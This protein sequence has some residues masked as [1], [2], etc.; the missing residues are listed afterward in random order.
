MAVHETGTALSRL[1]PVQ[2]ETAPIMAQEGVDVVQ[3][4][5]PP[6]FL[7]LPAELRLRVY[8]YII[9]NRTF[10]FASRPAYTGLRLTCRRIQSEFDHE[11]AKELRLEYPFLLPV[12]YPTMGLPQCRATL[13]T[14]KITYPCHWFRAKRFFAY[15]FTSESVPWVKALRVTYDALALTTR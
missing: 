2:A 1:S 9:P 12:P 14:L 11:A 5:S 3:P 10:P 15:M 7:S 6:A 13:S 8:T 4:K